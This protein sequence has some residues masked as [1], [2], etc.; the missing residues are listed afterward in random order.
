[1]IT[2]VGPDG[3]W[4]GVGFFAQSMNDK[5]YSIIVDGKGAVSERQM[6]RHQAG[7]LLAPSVKVVS[8]IVTDGQRTV[9]LSR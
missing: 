6:A 8:N 3:V 9:V 5:P 1:L 4:Y 2:L 7:T